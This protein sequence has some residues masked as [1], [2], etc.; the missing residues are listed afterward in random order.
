MNSDRIICNTAGGFPPP[1]LKRNIP[2]GRG[3]RPPIDSPLHGNSA[4]GAREP[5][6]AT[7]EQ[8]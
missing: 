4:L 3:S 7:G 5:R 6:E 1:E 2:Q 8:V